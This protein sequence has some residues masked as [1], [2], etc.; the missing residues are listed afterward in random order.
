MEEYDPLLIEWFTKRNL[1]ENTRKGYSASMNIY[2]NFLNSD[3]G[4]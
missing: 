3:G 1:T 2:L 4:N